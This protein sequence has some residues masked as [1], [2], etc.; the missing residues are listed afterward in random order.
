MRLSLANV[1]LA[2]SLGLMLYSNPIAATNSQA[3]L[4]GVMRTV[5]VAHQFLTKPCDADA[6][7][8]E[9]TESCPRIIRPPRSR[10]LERP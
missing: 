6:T 5:H 4:E 7:P 9:A 3:E 1:S 2:A 8:H 10:R